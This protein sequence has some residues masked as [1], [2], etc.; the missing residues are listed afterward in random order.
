MSIDSGFRPK[1]LETDRPLRRV[2]NGGN[3]ATGGV[4]DA[5]SV[6]GRGGGSTT[7]PAVSGTGG[8]YQGGQSTIHEVGMT[9]TFTLDE[10]HLEKAA[11]LNHNGDMRCSAAS[12]TFGEMIELATQ[13]DKALDS[14]LPADLSQMTGADLRALISTKLPFAIHA[15]S[16]AAETVASIEPPDTNGAQAQ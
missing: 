11:V 15:W 3:Y 8:S 14:V 10:A 6:V 13:I 4:G 2:Q 9:S 12:M 1:N 16:Q 5:P 7:Y